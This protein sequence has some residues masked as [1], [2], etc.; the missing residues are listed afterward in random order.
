MRVSGLPLSQFANP[1][2]RSIAPGVI[3]EEDLHVLLDRE[4]LH[5][6]RR[7]GV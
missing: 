6:V 4:L 7:C 2:Q 3:T 5:A 1:F